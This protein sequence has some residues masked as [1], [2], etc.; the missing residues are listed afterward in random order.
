MQLKLS[1]DELLKL[2][3]VDAISYIL[4]RQKSLGLPISPTTTAKWG[5][6][7]QI[8]IFWVLR[9]KD[10]TF[11]PCHTSPVTM[12]GR[13]MNRRIGDLILP[14]GGRER[15]SLYHQLLL[16]AV[17]VVI[18]LPITA[19][20]PQTALSAV[21]HHWSRVVERNQPTCPT[22]TGG[23]SRKQTRTGSMLS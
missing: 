21:T 20:T 3:Q 6:S 19:L 1:S 13:S 7:Y 22:Y 16:P 5:R 2:E 15:S 18:A 4:L 8:D 9:G 23:G 12:F 11:V 14:D 10:A 17:S